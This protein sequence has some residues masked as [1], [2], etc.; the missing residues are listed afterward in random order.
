MLQPGLSCKL[1]VDIEE[2]IKEEDRNL[3]TWSTIRVFVVKEVD[4]ELPIVLAATI[5]M[6]P[7]EYEL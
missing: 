5:N 2:V 1:K 7:T 4:E 6:P 3:S